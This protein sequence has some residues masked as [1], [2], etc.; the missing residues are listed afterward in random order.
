MIVRVLTAALLVWS[1]EAF[2][3][4]MQRFQIA[5]SGIIRQNSENDE[6]DNPTFGKLAIESVPTFSPGRRIKWGV[7]SE[8]IDETVAREQENSEEAAILRAE[9]AAALTNIDELERQRR[10]QAGIGG[11]ALTIGL[12]AYLIYTGAGPLERLPIFLPASLA[13]GFL[14]SGRTGL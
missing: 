3:P 14:E 2:R 8:P 7:F 13:F 12:A 4:P 11:S 5:K 1:G 10:T 9:A 6:F